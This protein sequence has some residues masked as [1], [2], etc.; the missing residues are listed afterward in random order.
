MSTEEKNIVEMGLI[1]Q[2]VYGEL[3]KNKKRGATNTFKDD[4]DRVVTLSNTYKV[5]DYVDKRTDM[6]ALLLERGETNGNGE[7]KGSGNYVVAFRGTGEV[8]DGVV[9]L[10]I[11]F[12]NINEQY[13]D[14]LDFTNK[15]LTKISNDKQCSID[16]A[17]SCLTRPGHSLEGIL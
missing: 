17:K 5:I 13:A 15:A 12:K 3:E 8:W 7:F 1:S 11:G 10:R 9:D 6:Q 2:I 14:A 4:E 16:E